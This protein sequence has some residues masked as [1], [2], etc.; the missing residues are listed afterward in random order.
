ME[1]FG[2]SE[3]GEIFLLISVGLCGVHISWH[4]CVFFFFF[5]LPPYICVHFEVGGSVSAWL[6]RR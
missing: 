6:V 3:C 2:E 4:L 1:K 5:G